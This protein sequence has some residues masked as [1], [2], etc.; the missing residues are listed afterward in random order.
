MCILND[1][2]KAAVSAAV[3]TILEKGLPFTGQSVTHELRDRGVNLPHREISSYTREI[4][5]GGKMPGWASTQVVPGLGP[6]M[7]FP[8]PPRSAAGMAAAKLRKKLVP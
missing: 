7:Y 6:V 4:F 5:N 3:T 2:E 8:V 1:S